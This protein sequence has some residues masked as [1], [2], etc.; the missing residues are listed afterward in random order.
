MKKLKCEGEGEKE[1]E[2]KSPSYCGE[3]NSLRG[4]KFRGK[5]GTQ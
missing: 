5:S 1:K 4:I 3:E 2:A